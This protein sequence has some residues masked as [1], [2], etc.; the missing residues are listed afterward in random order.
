[1]YVYASFV[2]PLNAWSLLLPMSTRCG[3][4]SEHGI[5]KSSRDQRE[6][7]RRFRANHRR[8]VLHLDSIDCV[9]VCMLRERA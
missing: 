6:G 9:P 5:R 1:M 4:V 3:P 2:L 7:N 8:L